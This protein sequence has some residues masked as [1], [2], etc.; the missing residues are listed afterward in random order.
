VTIIDTR[1]SRGIVRRMTVVR[2]FMVCLALIA[3]DAHAW[4]LAVAL[5]I[6]ACVS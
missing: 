3:L 5:L 4:W 6:L 2:F 1:V